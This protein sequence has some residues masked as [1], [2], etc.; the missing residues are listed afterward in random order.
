MDFKFKNNWEDAYES[1]VAVVM[2]ELNTQVDEGIIK[3]IQGYGID[4]DKE[5]LLKALQYDREQF[6]KGYTAGYDRAL[7]DFSEWLVNKGILGNRVI[8]DGEITDYGSLYVKMYK[9]NVKQ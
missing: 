6:E 2:K 9:Q 1:P 4:V 8:A 5:E 3:Y 7:Y